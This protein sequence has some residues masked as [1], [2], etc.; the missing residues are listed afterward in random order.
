MKRAEEA[1]SI[2]YGGV[3]QLRRAFINGYEQ[4]EKETIE[5]AFKW[6]SSNLTIIVGYYNEDIYEQV[7]RSDFIRKFREYME[8][9]KV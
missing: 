3:P 2:A 8:E 9:G 7:D 5:R 6:L 1:A 4:A